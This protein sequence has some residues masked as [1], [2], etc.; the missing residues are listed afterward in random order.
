MVL[1]TVTV[2]HVGPELKSVH[3]GH[4]WSQT[5]PDSMF[6]QKFNFDGHDFGP[7]GPGSKGKPKEYTLFWFPKTLK[8]AIELLKLGNKADLNIQLKVQHYDRKG[9]L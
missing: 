1:F 7:F 5:L 4:A 2:L 8:S 3:Q 9:D 6:A